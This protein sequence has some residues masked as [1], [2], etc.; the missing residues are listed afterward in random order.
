MRVQPA[1]ASVAL[2]A[3]RK[4][5]GRAGRL[6][7]QKLSDNYDHVL[8]NCLDASAGFAVS[9]SKTTRRSGSA[10][11]PKQ[12]KAQGVLDNLGESIVTGRFP[13]GARLPTEEALVRKLSVSRASLREG[14]NALARKGLIESRARR[15]TSVLAKAQWDVL[16]PDIL[17]WMAAGP[18]DEEFLIALLE[19]RT[20]LEPAA[21][22][23]AAQRASAAQILEIERAFR[24]MAD[25]V[26][27][28]FDRCCQHDLV[29]HEAILRASGNI[30]LSRLAVAIRAALLSII[31]TATN[32]RKSY[33]D[34]LADHWRVAVAIRERAPE[35]AEQAMRALLAGT[36]HDLKP[37]FEPLSGRPAQKRQG[38]GTR[39]GGRAI[40]GSGR[41][42]AGLKRMKRGVRL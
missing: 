11:D 37:V 28:D 32:V 13:P 5:S 7:T 27:R 6:L 22:R 31:R 24:G 12:R 8:D 16:D 20:I 42:P 10:A 9:T 34:S 33:Q 26:V 41:T 21:A 39:P 25:W 1:G 18:P 3:Q 23:L 40:N 30:L 29:F 38:R 2:C 15:G 35:E 19:A 17:R 4:P 14:L 36:A